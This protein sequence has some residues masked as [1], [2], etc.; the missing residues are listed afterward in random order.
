MRHPALLPAFL[1]LVL[2]GHPAVAQVTVNP[3]A[4]DTPKPPPKPAPAP[5]ARPAAKPAAAAQAKP[6][7][8]QQPAPPPM[9]AV[10][11]A[12]PP[13]P[14]IP[15][16]IVVPTRPIPPPSP[17]PIAADAPG[18]ATPIPDGLRVTFGPGR[19]DMNQATADAVRDLART[20]AKGPADAAFNVTALAAGA[21]DDGSAARRLS[22]A[23]G[24]AVRS[25]LIGEGIAS[26]R[27]FVRALG[28]SP[29]ALAGGPADRTDI[30]IAVP[31]PPKPSPQAK[32]TP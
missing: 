22:L 15:P 14:V 25:L 23:R 32:P 28:D 10:P 13:A 20:A 3:N 4:L 9:P 2:A 30:V 21:A 8:P 27:I 26:T 18:S 31:S 6:V 24:L 7:P 17:A 19:G 12:P 5:P 29:D 11:A 1:L 16:P